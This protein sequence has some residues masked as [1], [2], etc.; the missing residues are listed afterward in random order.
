MKKMWIYWVLAFIL[1]IGAAIYQRMTGPTHPRRIS[2]EINGETYKF[3]LPR[4]QG[5]QKDCKVTIEVPDES[6]SA[7]IYYRRYPTNEAWTEEFM[8][9]KGKSLTAWLPN[10]PPAGKLEYYVELISNGTTTFVAKEQP[11][12]IRYKGAVP[13]YILIPHILFMFA[14]MLLS[15]LALILAIARSPKVV[16]YT[17]ITFVCLFIGGMILGPVVQKFA[18][19]EYWTG[20]PFG[21]DLTDNK[22]LIGVLFWGLA[23]AGNFKKPRYYL[24][25]L[26]A[27]VLL[28]VYSIPHSAMGSELNYETGKVV[29]GY[30]QLFL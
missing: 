10:Q 24:V 15:N 28:A 7:K 16:L 27:L 2:T 5:G 30:I 22:T 18:F 3:H 13:A 17:K 19:G 1:T 12:K 20:V 23:L 14:A 9:R 11:V 21:F 26:A 8:V 29:T 25:I 6:V 4:S